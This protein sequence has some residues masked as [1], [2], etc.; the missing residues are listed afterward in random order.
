M[1]AERALVTV[2]PP[3]L[4]LRPPLP[5]YLTGHTTYGVWS[6]YFLVQVPAIIVERISARGCLEF[7]T[8][9]MAPAGLPALAL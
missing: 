2:H 1:H 6:S 3:A 5:R 8:C 4:T 7:R 9:N